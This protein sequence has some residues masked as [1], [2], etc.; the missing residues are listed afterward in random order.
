M[1][2]SPF[3]NPVL[4][5]LTLIGNK[6]TNAKAAGVKLRAGTHAN[7]ENAVITGKTNDLWVETSETGTFLMNNPT[8]LKNIGITSNEVKIQQVEGDANNPYTTSM[9]LNGGNLTGQSFT[10]T[11]KYVGMFDGKGAISADN[12]WTSGWTK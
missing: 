6:D 2:A 11:N 5:N 10:F 3:S 7:I 12:L 1:I 8:S 4:K 9:F